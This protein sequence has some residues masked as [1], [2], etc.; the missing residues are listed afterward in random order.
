[1]SSSNFKNKHHN[2]DN[3]ILLLINNREFSS[4]RDNNSEVAALVKADTHINGEPQP[5]L[6]EFEEDVIYFQYNSDGE[7]YDDLRSEMNSAVQLTH[8]H[9]TIKRMKTSFNESINYSN[10]KL[11]QGE[12]SPNFEFS[13]NND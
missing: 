11:A 9:S 8:K 3:N 2:T 7:A 12:K 1:M 13:Q 10:Q 6:I 4:L 5:P